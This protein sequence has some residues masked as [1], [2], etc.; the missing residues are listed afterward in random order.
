VSFEIPSSPGRRFFRN[1]GSTR[2][3]G[4]ELAA[5]GSPAAGVN[6]QVTWTYSDFRYRRYA[7]T[8]GGTTH[9]LDGQALPGIP[10]HVVRLSVR[11]RTPWPRDAWAEVETQHASG[12]GVD[13]TLPGRRTSPW[14]VTNLRVGW[15]GAFAALQNAF[16]R[17]Y[18]GSVV[19]NAA[20]GRYYE[21]AAGRNILFGVT[22]GAGH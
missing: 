3:R 14:W 9:V 21:P 16:N 13:D 2:H 1:A 20:A 5:A 6:V 15:R 7:F 22:L 17:K 10:Q 8:A 4:I 18:S 11:G 19:I 12:Y